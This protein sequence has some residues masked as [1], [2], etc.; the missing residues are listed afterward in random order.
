MSEDTVREG[1][2]PLYRLSWEMVRTSVL[3]RYCNADP[4]FYTNVKQTVPNSQIPDEHW[5]AVS[6]ETSDPWQQWRTLREWADQDRGFVRNV[7]LERQVNEP[8]WEAVDEA[9]ERGQS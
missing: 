4:I 3:A 5:Y 2:A 1:K 8:R 6:K 7:T 9:T